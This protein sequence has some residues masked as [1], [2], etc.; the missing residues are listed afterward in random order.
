MSNGKIS[1]MAAAM[2]G[3]AQTGGLSGSQ[4][5]LI[6]FRNVTK[7]FPGADALKGVS[8]KIPKG[9]VVGLLGHNGSGKSTFL[10]LIAGLH[11]P[12]RGEVFV[13]G[14]SPGRNT[15]TKVAYMPE[16]DHIYPWMTVERSLSFVSSFYKDW[17]HEKAER[18]LDF[19]KLPRR[20]R[21]GKLSK[22]MRGKLRLTM[23]MARSAPVV[24]L[25]EPLS[26][27]D[28][29]SRVSIVDALVSEFEAGDQTIIISTHEVLETESL[30]DS[31]IFLNEGE[32]ALLGDVDTLRQQYGA[33]V[34][35]LFKEVMK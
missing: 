4:Q 15:K 28:P 26:G 25:D 3:T 9:Q 2:T 10:K 13:A 20:N 22:G 30:F 35:D 7:L 21:V 6:E 19:F 34:Q 1:L 8:V 14:E 12:T 11:R 27:I 33:S 23:V 32:I 29:P 16:V 18:L 5:P 17:N 24:L 31:L